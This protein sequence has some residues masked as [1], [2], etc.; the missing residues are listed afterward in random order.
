MQFLVNTNKMALGD[1]LAFSGI[2]LAIVFL[3]L[4][5]IMVVIYIMS[6][7]FKKGQNKPKEVK[8]EAAPA[9]QATAEP[10]LEGARGSCGGIKLH[11]IEDKT[12]AMIMAIV[13]D[14]MHTPLNELRFISI[15]E[16]KG[17][18]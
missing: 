14:Q 2:G 10:A 9:V 8:P 7:F 16:V 13:A 6:L 1:A 17:D 4:I 11:G 12:A 18:R 15:E 5:F 3:V